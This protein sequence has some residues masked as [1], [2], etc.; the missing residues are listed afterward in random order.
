MDTFKAYYQYIDTICK[1]QTG[2]SLLTYNTPF[3]G[4]GVKT[5]V[6]GTHGGG[7]FG[8][9]REQ[10]F[11]INVLCG[12]KLVNQYLDQKG[13]AYNPMAIN[14]ITQEIKTNSARLNRSLEKEEIQAIADACSKGSNIDTTN[15]MK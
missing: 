2:Q 11:F 10:R 12:K 13:I 14:A 7:D 9:S 1:D 4:A 15:R 8:I 6:A 3:F 5:H